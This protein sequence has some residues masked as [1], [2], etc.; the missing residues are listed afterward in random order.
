MEEKFNFFGYVIFVIEQR[1]VSFDCS[2]QNCLKPVSTSFYWSPNNQ[3]DIIWLS[4]I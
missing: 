4:L 3:T 1:L 2:S